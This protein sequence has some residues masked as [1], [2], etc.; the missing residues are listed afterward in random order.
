MES[1]VDKTPDQNY[2]ISNE[3]QNQESP[4]QSNIN[5]ESNLIQEQIN[6]SS[7]KNLSTIPNNEKPKRKR[8]GKND[9]DGR[10][11]RCPDCDKCY[12]SAPALTNHRKM[13]HGYECGADGK[14]KGR[15]KKDATN[16]G[17]QQ[18]Q[19]NV[20]ENKYENFFKNENRKPP[21]MDQYV[22]DLTIK[23]DIL[24]D[25]FGMVY[26][27]MKESL[28]KDLDKIEDSPF[29]VLLVENWEKADPT[30]E[31]NKVLLNTTENNYD[32]VNGLSIEHIFFK[33]LRDVSRKT[34]KD[35]FWFMFKFIF[36]LRE[37]LNQKNK[38]TFPSDLVFDDKTLYTQLFNAEKIPDLC[39]D[40][41]IDFMEPSKFYGLNA[42]E[43]VEVI[44]HFCFWLYKN[45]F[46]QSHLQT[47]Q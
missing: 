42:Q 28:L 18:N 22:N 11:Y 15:P 8:R 31:E 30:F 46:T 19:K 32:K 12:L 21:S 14:N 34:N 13:K 29:Y 7:Q 24:K 41:Y 9:N 47:Y 43:L 26:S 25:Y 33:Y 1:N 10:N 39:N 23:L 5:Q 44:Q 4:F 45:G 36:I 2:I 20:I 6:D 40:F 38:E 37:F 17:V 27:H 16:D 3:V 35:Y